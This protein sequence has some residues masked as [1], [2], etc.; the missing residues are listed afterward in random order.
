MKS[1]PFAAASS[2]AALGFAVTLAAF[3]AEAATN[4][5]SSRS[6]IYRTIANDADQAACLAAGG[7]AH[8]EGSQA[9]LR[10]RADRR[11]RP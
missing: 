9:G 1:H 10:N 6:N 2:C 11:Q 4:L 5:N 3:P 8:H 7:K